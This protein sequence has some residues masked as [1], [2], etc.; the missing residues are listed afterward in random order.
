MDNNIALESGNPAAFSSAAD[1]FDLSSRLQSPP[2]ANTSRKRTLYYSPFD[3]SQT[4][5]QNLTNYYDTQNKHIVRLLKPVHEHVREAAE[6]EE[7]QQ[8][9]YSIAVYSSFICNIYL[10]GLQVYGAVA[11]GS[12]SLFTTMAD[13]IFDPLSNVTLIICNRQAKKAVSHKFPV[14]T[15]RIETAGN[16]FFSFIMMA[17]SLILVAFSCQ[18]LAEGGSTAFYLP[19][20]IAV[21]VAFFVK[22]C[23]F[24]YCFALRNKYSQ[25]RILWEDHRNDLFINGFGILTSVG[26]SKLKWW[27]DP[28]GLWLNTSIGEFKLLIG[29]SADAD[30]LNLITYIAMTHSDHVQAVDT[31]RAYHCGPRLIIEVDVVM[32]PYE[33]LKTCHDIAEDLQIKLESLPD[34]ERAFVHVDYETTHQ[35]EHSKKDI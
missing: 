10:S 35:P 29:V 34:V 24:I 33:T 6:A 5:T 32:R 8:L 12:L 18:E 3:K 14:G 2:E 13:S 26:G 17:V 30:T 16:I 25:V 20:V 21:S 4:K 15:S 19:S 11:S 9:Q 28:M 31:V 1:P 23:L 22:L 7:S 27:I